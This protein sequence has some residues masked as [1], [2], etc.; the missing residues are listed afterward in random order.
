MDSSGHIPGWANAG[1]GCIT[2]GAPLARGGTAAGGTEDTRGGDIP[3]TGMGPIG[4]GATAVSGGMLAIP[5][6]PAKEEIPTK[7]TWN[8]ISTFTIINARLLEEDHHFSVVIY[9]YLKYEFGLIVLKSIKN[10]VRDPIKR[11]QDSTRRGT[12]W[13]ELR[14]DENNNC[15]GLKATKEN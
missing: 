9:S 5:P 15:N 4:T 2:G 8:H 6:I 13:P 11:V 10:Y 7:F 14:I 12:Y 3:T 1:R